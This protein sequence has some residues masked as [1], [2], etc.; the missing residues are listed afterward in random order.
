M[1]KHMRSR[2]IEYHE[3]PKGIFARLI[4]ARLLAASGRLPQL[5]QGIGLSALALVRISPFFGGDWDANGIR[6]VHLLHHRGQSPLRQ[7]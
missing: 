7:T 5:P 1:H 3:Q 4:S 6:T 2:L